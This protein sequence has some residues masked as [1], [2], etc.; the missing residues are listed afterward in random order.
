MLLSLPK[1][2]I[3][4]C[5]VCLLPFS[6]GRKGGRGRGRVRRAGMGRVVTGFQDACTMHYYLIILSNQ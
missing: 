4:T 6:R 3:A 5:V 2:I 1:L